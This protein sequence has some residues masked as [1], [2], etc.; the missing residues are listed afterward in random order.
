MSYEYTL[1]AMYVHRSTTQHGNADAI[2]YLPLK[3]INKKIEK[4]PQ[5]PEVMLMLDT[6]S[7]GPIAC[8]QIQTWIRKDQLM[9]L[10]LRYVHSTT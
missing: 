6:T 9:S 8:S 2:S 1:A 3:S 4:T 7:E 5:P 10:V